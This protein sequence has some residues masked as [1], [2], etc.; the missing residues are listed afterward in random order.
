M[1]AATVMITPGS[2]T[3]VRPRGVAGIY[4]TSRTI[5]LELLAGCEGAVSVIALTAVAVLTQG[6]VR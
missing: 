2:C 5:V 3:R 1:V 4:F 6:A